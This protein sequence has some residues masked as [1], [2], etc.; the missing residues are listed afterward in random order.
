MLEARVG[1]TERT[2]LLAMARG[3]K[4]SPRHRTDPT[5]LTLLHSERGDDLPCPW[6]YG[7]T[8]E[9]DRQCSGCGRNF[10]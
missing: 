2:N 3:L 6:C 8:L 7:P 5:L 9:E 1:V 4:P 10:G